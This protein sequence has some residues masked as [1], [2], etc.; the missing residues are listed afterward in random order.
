MILNLILIIAFC[1]VL[2]AITVKCVFVVVDFL[3]KPEGRSTTPKETRSYIPN[4]YVTNPIIS[5]TGLDQNPIT[6]F[7]QSDYSTST[8]CSKLVMNHQVYGVWIVD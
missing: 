1:M 3:T 2:F 5:V 8:D 6:E 7:S 4:R